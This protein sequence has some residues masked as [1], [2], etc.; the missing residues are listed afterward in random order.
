[1]ARKVA[2]AL[3]LQRRPERGR[4]RRRHQGDVGPHF[5]RGLAAENDTGDGWVGIHELQGGGGEARAEALADAFEP[6]D[7]RQHVRRRRVVVER[8]PWP[9]EDAGVVGSADHHA[10][11]A[12]LARR[13]QAVQRRLLQQRIAA[14]EQEE[15]GIEL[16][17]HAL[18]RG[19]LVDAKA[20]R[21][22]RAGSAQLVERL[23]AAASGQLRPPALVGRR[24]AV[25]PRLGV[26][27]VEDV[28]A[29]EPEPLETRVERGQHALATIVEAHLQRRRCDVDA[30][31]LVA[32]R[33]RLEQPADLGRD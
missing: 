28:D 12:A 23:P 7:T 6:A 2:E 10:D 33:G 30:C 32:G 11:A 15:V 22:D 26:V 9:G 4:D 29:A 25:R 14:G 21:G 18:A 31:P 5:A 13:E 19:D 8:A 17:Q 3:L 1:M 27:D 16:G 20:D 24:R